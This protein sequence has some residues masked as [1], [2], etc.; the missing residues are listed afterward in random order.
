[1]RNGLAT[2]PVVTRGVAAVS[3]LPDSVGIMPRRI[4]LNI[5]SQFSSDMEETIE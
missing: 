1:M 5:C 3:R 2:L 4:I